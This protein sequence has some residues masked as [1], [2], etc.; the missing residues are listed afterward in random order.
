ML[1]EAEGG[2][3][4]TPPHGGGAGG[5]AVER[6]VAVCAEACLGGAD[7]QRLGVDDGWQL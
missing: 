1:G 6:P 5:V 4:G 7:G 3:R 2:R